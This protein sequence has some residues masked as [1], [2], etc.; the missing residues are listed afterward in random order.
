M[1]RL[2]FAIAFLCTLPT[3]T[4]GGS[5]CGGVTEPC[6]PPGNTCTG[7]NVACI[8][9]VCTPCGSA[10][11]DCCDGNTCSMLNLVCSAGK[12]VQCGA[13]SQAC[14]AGSTCNGG[15]NLECAA[16]VCT[17]CGFAGEDCCAGNT[18]SN[19]D[20]VCNTATGKCECGGPGQP[21]C[22]TP[23]ALPQ[24]VPAFSPINGALGEVL[25]GILVGLLLLVLGVRAM[26]HRN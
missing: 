12:C 21:A 25:S 8:G 7:F 2:F 6:C 5:E 22:P 20:L 17:P 3:V 14:C 23:T 13:S 11:E 10:G 4:W 26:R 9:G 19:F 24:P 16:G 1:W 18:C 15:P